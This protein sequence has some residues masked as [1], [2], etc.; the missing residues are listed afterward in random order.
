MPE[1]EDLIGRVPLFSG[2]SKRDRKGLAASLTERTFAAGT[3]ITDEGQSGLGFF[4]IESG[5]A[6]VAA[7]DKPTR[8][9]NAGDHF[10]EIAL[11]D[12]GPRTAT[13]TAVTDLH[14]YGMSVWDF[15]PFVQTHP[16]VGWA[17]LQTLAQMIRGDSQG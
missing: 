5:T 7:G 9:M 10:G 15:R 3:V 6:R 12:P 14:C 1:L 17:L 11:I 13:V 16:D 8:T 4:V 2:L